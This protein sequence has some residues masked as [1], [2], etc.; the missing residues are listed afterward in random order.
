M[1]AIT[2][3]NL[4]AVE[5]QEEVC[6][7]KAVYKHFNFISDYHIAPV[8]GKE[9]FKTKLP[10]LRRASGFNGVQKLLII[11][12]ADDDSKSAFDSIVNLLKK[13]NLPVP[14]APNIFSQGQPEVCVFIMPDKSEN[15]MLEDL[16]IESVQETPT[17]T[18]VDQ[19]IDCVTQLENPPRN[20]AK[21]KA[22]TYLAAMPKIINS[23]GLAAHKG[24]W[25]FDSIELNDLKS[26]LELL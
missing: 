22:Q 11:R 5:G 1:Q 23:V 14:V 17:M 7:I 26:V 16:C 4:I 10:A 15:G 25:N 24:Y 20:I 21:A 19:F 18:C 2:S 6:F 12:D 9:Q 8:G 13:E 3:N